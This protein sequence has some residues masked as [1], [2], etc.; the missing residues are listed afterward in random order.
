MQHEKLSF[1]VPQLCEECFCPV[2]EVVCG[3]VVATR[4]W[5]GTRGSRVFLHAACFTRAR[6]RTR[7]TGR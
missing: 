2:P 7:V 5:P 3:G 6:T 4:D 1:P